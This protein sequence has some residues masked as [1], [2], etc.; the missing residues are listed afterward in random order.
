MIIPHTSAAL[1]R[2]GQGSPAAPGDQHSTACLCEETQG[3]GTHTIL[4]IWWLTGLPHLA[5]NVPGVHPH[6]TIVQNSFSRWN[7]P[8]YV[9][10]RPRFAYPPI[11]QWTLQLLPHCSYYNWCCYEN[12]CTDLSSGS[13]FHF[14]GYPIIGTAELYG[15]SVFSFLRNHFTLLDSS[16]TILYSHWECTTVPTPL[17]PCQSLLFSGVLQVAI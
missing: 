2:N 17:H 16:C 10:Y 7:I 13:S 15:D 6:C 4:V 3:E 1:V 12:R 5:Y 8:F 11:R 9:L 14:G